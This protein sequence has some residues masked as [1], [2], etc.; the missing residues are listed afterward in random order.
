MFENHYGVINGSTELF[1]QAWKL[2]E[3]PKSDDKTKLKT[4]SFIKECYDKRIG[5][6]QGLP[7]IVIIN[8]KAREIN[9]EEKYFK[10]NNIKLN[11][12]KPMT[13]EEFDKSYRENI[14]RT[15]ESEAL[16]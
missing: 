10:D 12:E 5:L 14:L 6:L 13:M 11:Y 15:Q 16:F 2:L 3:N 1:K 4:M 7:Y 9:R 8:E